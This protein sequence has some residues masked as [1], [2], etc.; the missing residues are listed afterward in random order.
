MS[1]SREKEPGRS[2]NAFYDLA[3]DVMQCHSSYSSRQSQSPTSLG[4]EIDSAYLKKLL[5][6]RG[7]GME[8]EKETLM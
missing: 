4:G 3:S 5:I 6:F 2:H 1:V 8:R 7:S